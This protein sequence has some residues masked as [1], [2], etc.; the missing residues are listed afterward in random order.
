L[1]V[2]VIRSV[3]LF[4]SICLALTV[5]GEIG[6]TKKSTTAVTSNTR[7]LRSR[8]NMEV[9]AEKG[10]KPSVSNSAS[11]L[12]AGSSGTVSLKNNTTLVPE[13]SRTKSLNSDN[14]TF[15][16]RHRSESTQHTSTPV[17]STAREMHAVD[18]ATR[19]SRLKSPASAAEKQ[20][21][22]RTASVRDT[23]DSKKSP[24][25]P[26]SNTI[27]TS[28][29]ST[30]SSS[31]A[32]SSPEKLNQNNRTFHGL[33]WS[34]KARIST[35]QKNQR[36]GNLQ[37]TNNLRLTVSSPHLSTTANVDSSQTK[38]GRPRKLD[39]IQMQDSSKTSS[40]VSQHEQRKLRTVRNGKSMR[41]Q[42]DVAVQADIQSSAGTSR[43]LHSRL[44]STA[45][46]TSMPS[47]R[48]IMESC[49]SGKT[50]L[51]AKTSSQYDT[52]FE[53]ASSQLQDAEVTD[54]E[55]LDRLAR[56]AHGSPLSAVVPPS[57][58]DETYTSRKL[59]GSQIARPSTTSAE[60]PLH[61][62]TVI[63][64]RPSMFH[65]RQTAAIVGDVLD[66]SLDSDGASSAKR[67]RTNTDKTEVNERPPESSEPVSQ[68]A[69]DVGKKCV[70][71]VLSRD[72]VAAASL[73]HHSKVDGWNKSRV[74]V[75]S[76]REEKSSVEPAA[77]PSGIAPRTRSQNIF[78]KKSHVSGRNC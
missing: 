78:K 14:T 51:T 10:L 2:Y 33:P 75:S 64:A 46:V 62:S 55:E 36:V 72:N 13:Q 15:S 25:S 71:S 49:S 52:C 19:L 16:T 65:A 26:S 28:P 1:L 74:E 60:Q 44:H 67:R 18:S 53:S 42:C 3:L 17:K 6:R 22:S 11:G 32:W 23:S 73:E 58:D 31:V 39:K 12:P 54:D 77:G 66:A 27:T 30:R 8:R 35:Y 38:R 68:L 40:G 37:R 61:A 45:S 4:I 47:R 41:E 7:S 24:S 34:K 76:S 59:R 29:R 5:K 56:L 50:A 48:L 69:A 20:D 70:K 57:S 63:R 21:C 43:P 9:G